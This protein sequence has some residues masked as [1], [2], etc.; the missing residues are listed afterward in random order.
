MFYLLNKLK[1]IIWNI[2]W[3][4]SSFFCVWDSLFSDVDWTKAKCKL[5]YAVK[6][7]NLR[8]DLLNIIAID[9]S[10]KNESL[11][12]LMLSTRIKMNFH[13]KAKFYHVIK[14]RTLRISIKLRNLKFS[15]CQPSSFCLQK[16]LTSYSENDIRKKL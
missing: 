6:K 14:L 12:S 8:T 15:A 1:Q 16:G 9:K 2:L 10:H 4:I 3:K 7:K 11:L 13:S 5:K